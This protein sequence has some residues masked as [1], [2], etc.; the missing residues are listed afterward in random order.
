MVAM[1]L[2]YPL[3][4]AC[5]AKLLPE[6]CGRFNL[7]LVRAGLPP[8]ELKT[9]C[10]WLAKLF[11]ST[12]PSLSLLGASVTISYVFVHFPSFQTWYFFKSIK[13]TCDELFYTSVSF[14]DYIVRQGSSRHFV[15]LK[16]DVSK[17]KLWQNH[18]Y[19][20]IQET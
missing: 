15:N 4:V 17:T 11:S 10:G 5:Q 13:Y 8:T 1:L 3:H 12:R 14:L 6:V 19:Q 9:M 2:G 18:M 20:L 7:S 16:R